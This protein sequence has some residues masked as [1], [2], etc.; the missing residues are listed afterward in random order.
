MVVQNPPKDQNRQKNDSS[1]NKTNPPQPN[2]NAAAGNVQRQP[3]QLDKSPPPHLVDDRFDA[4]ED[5]DVEEE[6]RD[7]KA[8]EEKMEFIVADGIEE[9]LV[10]DQNAVPATKLFNER[11]RPV[12]LTFFA[13]T[14]YGA[15]DN[16]FPPES[17]RT[18]DDISEGLTTLYEK[19]NTE[20]L[21]ADNKLLQIKRNNE[22]WLYDQR[23]DRGLLHPQRKNDWG[24][25]SE[26]ELTQLAGRKGHQ[27]RREIC[28]LRA[29]FPYRIRAR[30]PS[31]PE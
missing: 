4:A 20:A 9:V 15:L 14:L 22:Q 12:D 16:I 2:S 25:G 26:I 18:V 30:I 8:L 24:R 5:E 27:P 13:D 7:E 17:Q 10:L 3:H 21:T 23:D 31:Q 11:A 19:L 29:T 28:R 6:F 1:S